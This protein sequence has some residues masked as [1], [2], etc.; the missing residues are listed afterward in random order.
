MLNLM[1]ATVYDLLQRA[2]D[3]AVKMYDVANYDGDPIDDKIGEAIQKIDE[4]RTI[5]SNL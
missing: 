5:I 4:A 3:L 2:E 1:K